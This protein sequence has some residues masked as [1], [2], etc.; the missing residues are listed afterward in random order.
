MGVNEVGAYWLAVRRES[1]SASDETREK[2]ET[3]QEIAQEDAVVPIYFASNFE[4]KNINNWSMME[5]WIRVVLRLTSRSPPI[6]FTGSI[7]I[8]TYRRQTF[9]VKPAPDTRKLSE[10][11]GGGGWERDGATI[12]A[13]GGAEGGKI[14]PPEHP[15]PTLTSLNEHC[16]IP[17]SRSLSPFCCPIHAV[18]RTV[19]IVAENVQ[20]HIFIL[21]AHQ[22]GTQPAHHIVDQNLK[23]D[24]ISEVKSFRFEPERTSSI[25]TTRELTQESLTRVKLIHSFRPSDH[26]NPRR[27]ESSSHK[28]QRLLSAPDIR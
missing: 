21:E 13:S 18:L 10:A 8:P 15:E 26:V 7:T 28:R 11:G 9:H 25:L 3:A 17:P 1:A 4:F 24:R 20:L 16:T 14:T 5:L 12:A 6:I 2:W 22:D 23:A 27:R 19:V